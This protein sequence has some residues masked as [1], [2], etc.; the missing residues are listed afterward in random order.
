MFFMVEP[1]SFA[2]LIA[3]LRRRAEF[4]GP[5]PVRIRCLSS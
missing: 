4:F 2:M 1:A 5:S 3:T